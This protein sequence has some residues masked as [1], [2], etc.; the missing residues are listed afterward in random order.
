MLVIVEVKTKNTST[1]YYDSKWFKVLKFPMKGVL[2]ESNI[3]Q[4][5]ITSFISVHA[6]AKLSQT[7]I[8]IYL[9]LILVFEY[10][11]QLSQG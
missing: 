6:Q 3:K 8:V 7:Q 1:Q 10:H 5:F 2:A 11:P 9:C 4:Y